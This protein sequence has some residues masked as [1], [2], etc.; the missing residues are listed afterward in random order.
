M[1]YVVRW[2]MDTNGFLKAWVDD[3]LVVDYHGPIGFADEL[4]SALRAPAR[5]DDVR[6]LGRELDG[7]RPSDVAGRPRDQGRLVPQA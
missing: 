4:G 6:A 7:D 5:Y 1:R 2:L 3:R